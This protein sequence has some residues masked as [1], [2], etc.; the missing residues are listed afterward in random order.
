MLCEKGDD[1]MLV[2]KIAS[3]RA[4]IRTWIGSHGS[5]LQ[6]QFAGFSGLSP[7]SP[8]IVTIRKF[9]RPRRP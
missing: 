6:D 7:T 2:T 5:R 9:A 8:V 3:S 4:Q 1:R